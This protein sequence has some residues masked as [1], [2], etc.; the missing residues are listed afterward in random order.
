MKL[1]HDPS[2]KF[3]PL[4]GEY[5]A[6]MAK[7]GDAAVFAYGQIMDE[8]TAGRRQHDQYT[9]IVNYTDKKGAEKSVEFKLSMAEKIS[10]KVKYI[11]GDSAQVRSIKISKAE[12]PLIKSKASRIALLT[13]FASQSALEVRREMEEEEKNSPKLHAYNSALRDAGIVPDTQFEA[14]SGDE[15]FA[16]VLKE[17]GSKGLL[18]ES[19]KDEKALDE[20]LADEVFQRNARL[21]SEAFTRTS[22][23]LLLPIFRFYMTTSEAE[24]E[25]SNLYPSLATAP[26]EKQLDVLNLLSHRALRGVPLLSRLVARK[27]EAEGTA[28]GIPASAFGAAFFSLES[29]K[30]IKWCCQVLGVPEH[31]AKDAL[32]KIS[33]TRTGRGAEFLEKARG[34]KKK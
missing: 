26:T 9:A 33:A 30:D 27:L 24:R 34:K 8:F 17:L 3:L 32:S 18:M 19:G 16:P 13:A 11:Y 23:R 28:A 20:Q 29:K 22:E 1:R 10:E 12:P 15:R 6:Q 25:G 2:L 7:A 31:G 21:R 14:F 5:V 4:A